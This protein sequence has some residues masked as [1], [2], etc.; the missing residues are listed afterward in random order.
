MMRV[1]RNF[2]LA[3]DGALNGIQHVIL[4]R[5]P[6]YTTAFRRLLRGSGVMRPWSLIRNRC[7]STPEI[8]IRPAA[9]PFRG[10]MFGRIGQLRM[11]LPI[12]ACCVQ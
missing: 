7:G 11:K 2:T 12:G 4:D 1:A 9:P 8:T 5:D 6:F 10:R 3:G